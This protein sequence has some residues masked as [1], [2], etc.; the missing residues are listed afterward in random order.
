M[1]ERI[2]VLIAEDNEM[3][4]RGLAV[5]L[6]DCDDLYM[7]GTAA[8]GQEAVEMCLRLN[9]DVV[10]MDVNMPRLNGIA[11]TRVIRE[12][13][14]HIRIVILTTGFGDWGAKEALAAGASAFLL[15]SISVQE[16]SD[17]IRAAYAD[18][19]SQPDP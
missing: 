14:P 8:D 10:L 19:R 6:E 17:A 1:E 2:K 18:G 7:I 12:Q 15:K 4:R 11:A 13:Q 16:I 5:F 9:P 3:L